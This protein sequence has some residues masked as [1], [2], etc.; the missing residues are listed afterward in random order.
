RIR[1]TITT[2]ARPMIG[3]TKRE[4]APSGAQNPPLIHVV[5][6]S[7]TRTT[8]ATPAAKSAL[9]ICPARQS[10]NVPAMISIARGKELNTTPVQTKSLSP[11]AVS[12]TK[13]KPPSAALAA[14]TA[15]PHPSFPASAKVVLSAAAN[16]IK[17]RTVRP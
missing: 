12:S 17:L 16:H 14:V 5:P 13:L 10:P 7:S 11:G 15:P 9:E 4:Y 1:L 2:H 3:D 6:P 8:A